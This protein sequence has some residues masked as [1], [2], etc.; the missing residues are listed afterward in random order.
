MA[1][2]ADM[3]AMIGQKSGRLYELM[4]R[5]PLAR[6]SGLGSSGRSV[7]RELERERSR[8]A[9]EL[10]AGAGQ[11]LAGMKLNL[12]ILDDCAA[13]LPQAGRDALARLQR[14]AEQAMEQVRAASHNL[15]P[16]DW[17]GL[18]I[19]KALRDLIHSSGLASRI[20]VEL[21]I[22]PLPC[23]P[24]HAVKIAI[25][26]CVQECISNV[27]RHSGATRFALTLTGL[28]TA[29]GGLID[30]CLQDNGHGFQ[31]GA[32]SGRGGIGLMAIREHT[33]ALGGICNISSTR[34]GVSV[35]VQLPLSA[36]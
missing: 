15:H 31:K 11:P 16:P 1:A 7:V 22:Q 13:L 27:S 25:Y 8:I 14:L 34:G 32:S 21:D 35:R 2:W 12:E 26:R 6:R 36:E 9:R 24:S 33:E 28:P 23:E 4:T 18:S 20:E 17:Q 5:D 19:E 10:H 30:L 29:D 3:L